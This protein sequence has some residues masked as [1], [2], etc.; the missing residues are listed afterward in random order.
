MTDKVV[1]VAITARYSTGFSHIRTTRTNRFQH[2]CIMQSGEIAPWP[3]YAAPEVSMSMK[4]GAHGMKREQPDVGR[5]RRGPSGVDD[6]T[7]KPTFDHFVRQCL[8]SCS[9]GAN[10]TFFVVSS[11]YFVDID[12]SWY[13]LFLLLQTRMY[14]VLLGASIHTQCFLIVTI[15][16]LL[17]SFRVRKDELYH[18]WTRE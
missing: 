8:T 3:S 11:F 12:H 2:D 17:G 16:V 6:P 7:S 5:N 15:Y 13:L 1:V 10:S 18:G 9:T 4:L 14:W